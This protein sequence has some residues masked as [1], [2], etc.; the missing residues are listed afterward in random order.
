MSGIVFRLGC[1]AAA[2]GD[3]AL[4]QTLIEAA[5]DKNMLHGADSDGI[6]ALHTAAMAGH[7]QIVKFL[8]A[9]GHK[10]RLLCVSVNGHSRES[11]W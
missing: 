4:V 2:S 7:L 5:K 10:V 3:I 11:V 8:V 6:T 9:H 1:A